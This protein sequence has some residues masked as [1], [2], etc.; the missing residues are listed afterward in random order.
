GQRDRQTAF[1]AALV[2]E[3]SG[4]CRRHAER[5]AGLLEGLGLT[6]ECHLVS[7]D[8]V[9][10][11]GMVSVVNLIVRERVDNG[12]V[13][14]LNAHRDVVPPGA[15]WSKDPNGAE[16]VNG[17]SYGCGVAVSKSDFATYTWALLALKDLGVPLSGSVE[18]HFTYDEETGGG[19][20]P[21]WLLDRGLSRPDYAIGAGFSYGI[22]TAHNGCL[23]L[24][25]EMRGRSAHAAK[26]FTGIDALEAAAHVLNT[27]YAWR[28][29]LTR[30]V[31]SFEAI[32]SPQLTVGLIE[33]AA[34]T[35]PDVVVG[36]RRVPIVLFGAG[37]RTIEDA[38]AHRADERLCLTDLYKATEAA[39]LALL[40]FLSN[41]QQQ[42]S[43]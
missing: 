42:N 8:L 19:I 26:P 35:F 25:V 4:D 16:I 6:V 41:S 24:E 34:R 11:G 15:G 37:P 3:P 12:P 18:L 23:H 1:L 2:K 40:D 33:G 31:S 13:V 7:A 29:T 14:A 28:R 9:T 5:T 20:G 32:G 39:A 38:N 36:I 30:R 27:L 43:I 22:V 10:E 17:W 21:A